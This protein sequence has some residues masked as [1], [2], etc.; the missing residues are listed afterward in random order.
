MI[1]DEFGGEQGID[2]L[3]VAAEMLDGVAHGGQ[4][5]NG[6]HA[7]EILEQNARG[8]EGDF[9]FRGGSGW[10]PIREGANVI[11]VDEAV[12]FVAQK[13]FE[14][15]LQRKRL[16]LDTFEARASERVEA[17]KFE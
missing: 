16:A 1:D 9:F 15:D 4:I 10:I 14:Q 6:R 5:D 12:V 7:R 11:L 8:H 3:R 2:F 13:I 17:M